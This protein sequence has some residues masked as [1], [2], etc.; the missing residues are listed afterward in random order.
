MK[1]TAEDMGMRIPDGYEIDW[2]T[3]NGKT[4]Y[5]VTANVFDTPGSGSALNYWA[6]VNWNDRRRGRGNYGVEMGAPMVANA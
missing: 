4:W 5:E 3:M 2:T 6:V 1:N